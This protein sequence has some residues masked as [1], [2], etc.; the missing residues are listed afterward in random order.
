VGRLDRFLRLER[1]R[2]DRKDGGSAVSLERFRDPPAYAHDDPEAERG[3]RS[4]VKC[5]AENQP[6]AA[7]CFNCDAE[8]D[9][10]EMREHQRVAR[11]RAREQDEQRRREAEQLA[12]RELEKLRQESAARPG[13]LPPLDFQGASPLLWA[14]RGLRVIEDPWYRFAVRLALIV[15]FLGLLFWSLW[16]PSRYPFL[17]LAVLLLGGGGFGGRRWNRWG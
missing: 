4:C 8:L 11:R 16:A 15:G 9:T 1:P 13:T 14:L 6:I 3:P 17:L 2:P 7:R 10:A 5:G 12:E